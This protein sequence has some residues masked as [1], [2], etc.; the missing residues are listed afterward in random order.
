MVLPDY[1]ARFKIE[2]IRFAA[3]NHLDVFQAA[4][5]KYIMRYDAKNGIE[6]LMKA[7]RYLD[8]YIK[9]LQGDPDW[10]KRPL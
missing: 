4:V 3:E 1:Y 10:W 7:K 9:F 8:M 6:D 2:P 5:M